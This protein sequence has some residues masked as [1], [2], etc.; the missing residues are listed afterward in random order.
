MAYSEWKNAGSQV[1][2]LGTGTSFNIAQMFPNDYTNLTADN[3]L[4][5]AD[6]GTISASGSGSYG[7]STWS[8]SSTSATNITKN[9]DAISGV[10]TCKNTLSVTTKVYSGSGALK[11]NLA[12]STNNACKVYLVIGD[13]ETV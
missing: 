1:Y 4:V 11:I 6:D 10:L 3:F 13:I 5:V 9:Y 12:N 8:G 2:Y 7:S